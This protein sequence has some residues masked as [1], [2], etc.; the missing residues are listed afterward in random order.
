MK[1]AELIERMKDIRAKS[2]YISSLEA[3]TAC[4]DFAEKLDEDK[5]TISIVECRNICEHIQ[6]LIALREFL[7]IVNGD[8]LSD[9]INNALKE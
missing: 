3:S 5:Y 9:A 7:T 4:I 1:K 2:R 8:K 6:Q